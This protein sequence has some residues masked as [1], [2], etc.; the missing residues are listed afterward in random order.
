[1]DR[2]IE[3]R[4][5]ARSRRRPWGGHGHGCRRGK[6]RHAPRIQGIVNFLINFKANSLNT[7]LQVS[8][9]ELSQGH[10]EANQMS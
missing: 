6:I 5:S 9:H 7:N 2:E 3:G 4:A 1:M 10:T 8:S